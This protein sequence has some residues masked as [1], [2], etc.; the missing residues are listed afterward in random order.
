MRRPIPLSLYAYLH[1]CEVVPLLLSFYRLFLFEYQPLLTWH[2][3][4]LIQAELYLVATAM[5]LLCALTALRGS[6]WTR[7]VFICWLLSEAF[8]A[9]FSDRYGGVHI[10]PLVWITELVPLGLLF[11]PSVSTYL[12]TRP[13]VRVRWPGIGS[14]VVIVC[15][16]FS[17]G[18]FSL[19][20]QFMLATA[21]PYDSLES[22]RIAFT[23]PGIVLLAALFGTRQRLRAIREIG[24]ALVASA[25]AN[26]LLGVEFAILHVLND[27]LHSTYVV[28]CWTVFTVAGAVL[29]VWGRHPERTVT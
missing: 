19:S 18:A 3:E 8:S 27:R 5:H 28:W 15:C 12:K 10:P 26:I 25:V 2:D 20:M 13:Q 17:L 11:M 29:V 22:A 4:W 14:V 24:V 6:R 16:V 7:L 23:V 21:L 1:A 9:V